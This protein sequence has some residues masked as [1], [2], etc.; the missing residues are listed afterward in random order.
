MATFRLFVHHGRA[1]GS[2]REEHELRQLFE[3]FGQVT[4]FFTKREWKNSQIS[5]STTDEAKRAK[6]ELDKTRFNKDM[7]LK[8]FFSN[9]SRRVM[10]RGLPVASR[11]R[12]CRMSSKGRLMLRRTVETMSL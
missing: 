2:A 7:T 10:V 3:K 8:I 4:A 1:L 5:F 12:T 11:S 9:P 6:E